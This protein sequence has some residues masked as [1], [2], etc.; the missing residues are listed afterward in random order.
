MA[1]PSLGALRHA[2]LMGR[3]PS[4]LQLAGGIVVMAAVASLQLRQ[5]GR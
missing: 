5:I 2:T 1:V 3:E 4:W